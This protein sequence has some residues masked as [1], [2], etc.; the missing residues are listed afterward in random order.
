[1]R[2]KGD[3]L[4]IYNLVLQ[5]KKIKKFSSQNLRTYHDSLLFIL[6][7]YSN[8][9]LTKLAESELRRLTE[10]IRKI[11]AK[12]PQFLKGSG[13][14]ETWR[15]DS[16]TFD[17]LRIISHKFKRDADFVWDAD[18]LTEKLD[19]FLQECLF[20]SERDAVLCDLATTSE[21]ISI[22][23]GKNDNSLVWFV[24]EFGRIS[25]PEK[26]RDF[27]IYQLNLWIRWK[28][29]KRNWSRT[30][31][32]FPQNTKSKNELLNVCRGT[33]A[34][35]ER[36][37]DTVIYTAPDRVFLHKGNDGVEIALFEMI[38][39]R[40]LP[41]ESYIGFVAAKNTIPVA[42]GGAWI[43]GYRAEIGVNIF[44]E[45]RGGKSREL[46]K[47][48]MKVYEDVYGVKTFLVHQSQF[49]ENNE[50][51]IQSGA[52]W[53]YYR[54]GFRPDS[55]KLC[56]LAEL[57][58]RKKIKNHSYKSPRRV[59][60]T[61][62]TKQVI[63]ESGNEAQRRDKYCVTQKI[64]Y[65]LLKVIGEKF[66]GDK[67]KARRG[68]EKIWYRLDPKNKAKFTD[69]GLILL[70]L[71]NIKYWNIDDKKALKNMLAMKESSSE[72]KFNN[73]FQKHDKFRNDLYCELRKL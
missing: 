26:T 51:A 34:V 11:A 21:L 20:T 41:L 60:L 19:Q 70:V 66:G 17:L 29:S 12:N 1:M 23:S 35:R 68:A 73:C 46:F 65:L 59:L 69:F 36:E 64:G 14:A 33:L 48:I 13:I 62:A 42:Y 6:S 9:K 15:E 38:P 32:R 47:E 5:I 55:K 2:A 56:K 3:D 49:G 52:F 4:P 40:R 50:E 37:T 28:L 63:L 10:I 39:E 24:R 25:L 71:K 7:Q 72:F 54:L 44:E 53:F 27:L 45:F 31:L 67:E 16:F 43:L 18:S 61:L 30:F 58:A 22:L 8:G 57:E